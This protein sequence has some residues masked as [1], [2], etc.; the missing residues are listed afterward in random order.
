M[1]VL[2]P[3]AVFASIISI[4]GCHRCVAR[5]EKPTVVVAILAAFGSAAI[6]VIFVLIAE[7]ASTGPQ[8][9][10]STNYWM[11]DAKPGLLAVIFPVIAFS[12]AVSIIPASFVVF[13][14]QRKIAAR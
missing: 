1:E 6:S 13:L 14:N 2:I 11:G 3:I 10:F 5:E 8:I 12:I 9:A 7:L 4:V